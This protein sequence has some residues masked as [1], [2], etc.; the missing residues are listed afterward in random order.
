M[1][2]LSIVAS[3]VVFGLLA[4]LAG[5]AQ[6]NSPEAIQATVERRIAET[7]LEGPR[8]ALLAQ[9]LQEF[10]AVAENKPAWS[11]PNNVEAAL[12]AIGEAAL[13]GLDPEDFGYSQIV[14]LRSAGQAAALDVA[15][16][17][18][19]ALLA[20]TLA[21][22]KVDPANV[23]DAVD[24]GRAFSGDPIGA[25]NRALDGGTLAEAIDNQRPR[26]AYYARLRS[27]LAT[28]R[29]AAAAGG[30]PTVTDGSTL[31]A[32]DSGPRVAE[33]TARLAAQGLIGSGT[34]DFGPDVD[35]AVRRFQD[36]HGLE[37]DGIVGPGTLAALIVTAAER[38]DQ[39][40]VNMERARWIGEI[41][42]GRQI[43]VNIAGFY[44]SLIED[45]RPVWTTRTIVGRGYTR[46]P[47]FTDKMEYI[48]FNPTW[49]V[50]RSIVRGE[51]A[52]KILA[53][54]GYLSEHGYYLA[55]ASGQVVDPASVNWPGL[56]PQNFP[57]WVVQKPG[58]KNALGLVKFMFPNDYSVYMHDT[59]QRYLFDRAERSFSHGC[60]RT[61]KPLDLAGLLLA[62]QGW[63]RPRIDA[64]VAA[65]KTTRVT[66]DTPVPIAILYWTVD[67]VDEVVR[68]YP[69]LYNRDAAVLA[70]LDAPIP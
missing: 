10:Y 42:P 28:Y 12:Q 7:A 24:Y 23:E 13:D 57:Y 16:T 52:P 4:G 34:P 37:A 27:A 55:E 38:A 43:L 59:P 35:T 8:R 2:T 18:N 45:G 68:F 30:W 61:E 1:H 26:L 40:R 64:A 60:I 69:D 33:L 58:S 19:V 53:D 51:L 56:T 46:T 3:A 44:A 31:R 66:L 54:P 6:A 62:R 41:G 15:L 36:M 63:D 5:S 49:T 39:I 29:T 47:V 50:P 65:G 21:H 25:L 9:F 22:G 32:G 14:A 20:Y 17:E 11:D 70:L 48:E 67:P